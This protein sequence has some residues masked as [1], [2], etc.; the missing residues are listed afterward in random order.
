MLQV[1]ILILS[2]SIRRYNACR[3][4]PKMADA[5]EIL[6]PVNFSVSIIC[7]R[8]M[9]S[10]AANSFVLSFGSDMSESSIMLLSLIKMALYTTFFSCLMFPGKEYLHSLFIAL[11]VNLI[12]SLKEWLANSLINSGISSILSRKGGR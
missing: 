3:E 12:L 5:R 7:L 11:C 2:F 9:S 4:S 1:H 10:S 8:S 6:P